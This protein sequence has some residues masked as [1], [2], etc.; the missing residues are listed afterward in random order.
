MIHLGT[1]D[2][3]DAV[4]AGPNP[5]FVQC[6]TFPC[7]DVEVITHHVMT[8]Q[9]VI[10]SPLYDLTITKCIG[11]LLVCLYKLLKF[12]ITFHPS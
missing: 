11:V 4:E 2:A 3:Q 7:R 8:S 9:Y 1:V 5:A 6:A 10:I 12:Y